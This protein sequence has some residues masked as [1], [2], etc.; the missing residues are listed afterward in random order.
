MYCTA[1]RTSAYQRRLR[2]RKK[3]TLRLLQY[4]KS[5][6]RIHYVKRRARP[7]HKTMIDA[8]DPAVNVLR[9][10]LDENQPECEVLEAV[11]RLPER[12]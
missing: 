1:G 8:L 2:G 4:I 6:A 3:S 7:G 9:R 11:K 12:G 10:L 5:Y